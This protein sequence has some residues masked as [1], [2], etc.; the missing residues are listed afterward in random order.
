MGNGVQVGNTGDCS[1]GEMWIDTSTRSHDSE[2]TSNHS[3][4]HRCRIERYME[5]TVASMSVVTISR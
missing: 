4:L 1:V 2:K 5:N 3:N